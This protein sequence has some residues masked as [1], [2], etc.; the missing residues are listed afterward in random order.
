V[1]HEFDATADQLRAKAHHERQ[2][3]SAQYFEIFD[4]DDRPF[5]TPDHELMASL[6]H[7]VLGTVVARAHDG[8]FRWKSAV[9]F[10]TFSLLPDL[11]VLAFR[12]GIPYGAPFGHRGATHSVVFALVIAAAGYFI[13]Q[14]NF[15]T[16]LVLF[17]VLLSHPLL[18]MLTDG[19]LG[20]ALWW[21]FSNHR[22]FFPWRPLPVAP[23]GIGILSKRGAFVVLVESAAFLPLLLIPVNRKKRR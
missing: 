18:D 20:V 12:F 16:T 11:D 22:L 3:S 10:S 9:A 19:G 1:S 13:T 17:V 15:R 21:P 6:G 5:R 2:S 8:E 4:A 7:V 23:L 14:R